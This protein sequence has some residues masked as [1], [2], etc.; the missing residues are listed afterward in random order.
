M[1]DLIKRSYL[2][3]AIVLNPV[4]FLHSVNTILS[5]I[6]PPIV[7]SAA[8]QP[9]PFSGL[10]PSATHPHLDIHSSESF[11]W[12]YT[13]VMVCAQL[14]AFGRVSQFREEHR[15]RKRT[16]ERAAAKTGPTVNG[17][18]GYKKYGKDPPNGYEKQINGG[19]DSRKLS[20]VHEETYFG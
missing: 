4:L 16:K 19:H 7:V 11:C 20:I 10:G 2:L 5:R 12:S 17:D 6:L 18:A 8:I 3:P 13:I 9:P 14:V 15:E 1:H